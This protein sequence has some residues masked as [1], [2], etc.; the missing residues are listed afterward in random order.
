ME[1]TDDLKKVI[2]S[3][4]F[5]AYDVYEKIDETDEQQ[6]RYCFSQFS[7]FMEN[8]EYFENIKRFNKQE[9]DKLLEQAIGNLA[10][11]YEIQKEFENNMSWEDKDKLNAIT[12]MTF[13]MSKA[14]LK[15]Y[16]RVKQGT[17]LADSK[18]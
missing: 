7:L 5:L 14:F 13:I 2:E 4:N 1:I 11:I 9:N 6:L 16:L 15:L 10:V 17:W 8:N 12:N 18:Q 3:L